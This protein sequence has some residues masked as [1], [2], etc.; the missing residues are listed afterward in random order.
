MLEELD[1]SFCGNVSSIVLEAI[2]RG[3]PL[4]K[5]FKFNENGLNDNDEAFAIARN[6]SNLRHL[7]LVRNSLD[8]SGVT[9]ILDGCPL[10]ESL[11]LRGCFNVK[12]E[13]ELRRRCDE[14]LKDFMEPDTP[15][16]FNGCEF[17][18]V[19]NGTGHNETQ[20]FNWKCMARFALSSRSFSAQ[21]LN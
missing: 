10:L 2:G 7:Q 17:V 20:A 9:A 15:Y 13:G 19:C 1:I 3:C 18:L 8:N 11:D 14:R 4:L 21:L 12:L 6:M 5:S 16:D